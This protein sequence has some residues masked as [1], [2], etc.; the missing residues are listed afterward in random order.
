MTVVNGKVV[1]FSENHRN[2]KETM[3]SHPQLEAFKQ[4]VQ[5]FN[6]KGF[7]YT[8]FALVED[9]ISQGFISNNQLLIKIQAQPV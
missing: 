7:G 5:D 9:I 2:I 8:E 4:P 1:R 6:T 3:I